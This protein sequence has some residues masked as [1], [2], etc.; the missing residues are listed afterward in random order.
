MLTRNSD[1]PE[2]LM[3]SA[4]QLLADSILAYFDKDEREGEIRFYLTVVLTFWSGFESGILLKCYCVP[5][6]VP[7]PIAH[8]LRE[9]ENVVEATGAIG[10]RT[11][12]QSV[13]DR[14]SVFI[15]FCLWS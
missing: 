4:L 12:Y 9:T 11:R 7:S 15:F 14:Y 6:Q 8:F 10:T 1:M 5:C 2:R 3:F 13:L